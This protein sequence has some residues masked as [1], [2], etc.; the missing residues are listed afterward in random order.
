MNIT[1][2]KKRDL[3]NQISQLHR[4]EYIPESEVKSLCPKTKELLIEESN[5]QPIYVPVTI[6]G[7]IHSQ[8]VD[9]MEVFKT[10]GSCL[11]MGDFVD[12]GFNSVEIFLLLLALTILFPACRMYGKIWFKKVWRYFTEIFDLL[13]LDA[14]IDRKIFCVHGGLSSSINLI[15]EI[16]NINRK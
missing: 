14:I 11:F 3:D 12:C 1:Q 8:F 9:L 16:K 4:Y 6:C 2:S 10:G 15:D 7:D 13:S 5:V